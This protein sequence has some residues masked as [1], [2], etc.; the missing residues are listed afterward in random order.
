MKDSKQVV[1]MKGFKTIEDNKQVVHMRGFKTM[2]DSKQVVHTYIRESSRLRTT[3]K[4]ISN[5]QDQVQD[6]EK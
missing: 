5:P 6:Y 3:A 2:N 1:H 4:L